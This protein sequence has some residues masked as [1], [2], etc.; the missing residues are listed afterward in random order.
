[1]ADSDDL[2]ATGGAIEVAR[3]AIAKQA[4]LV[5]RTVGNYEILNVI[6]E[7]GMGLVCRARRS[8]GTFEREV[9]LKL[10]IAARV[11]DEWKTRFRS[12]QA[13]LA[14][15]DHLH[16]TRLYDAGFSD[17][18]WPYFVMELIDGQHIDAWAS[19]RSASEIVDKMI[20]VCDAVAFAHARLVVHRDIKPSNVL[21]DAAGTVKLADFGIAKILDAPDDDSATVRAMTPRFASPEQLRAD[22]LTVASDVFQLGAL[23][24]HTLGEPLEEVNL[25][26]AIAGAVRGDDVVLKQSERQRLGRELASIIEK[27]LRSDPGHR[28]AGADALA[29]DLRAWRQGY[30]VSAVM[31]TAS[32]RLRKLVGRNRTLAGVLAAAAIVLIASTSFYVVN[33]GSA[34]NAAQAQAEAADRA[35]TAMSRLLNDTLTTLQDRSAEA[36]RGDLSLM[37]SVLEDSAR[38]LESELERGDVGSA[39]LYR[40]RGDVERRMGNVEAARE[41][42]ENALEQLDPDVDPENYLLTALRIIDV[43]IDERALQDMPQRFEALADLTALASR[44]LEGRAEFHRVR[45]SFLRATARLP[46]ANEASF[47]ALELLS[48][49]EGSANEQASLFYAITMGFI[50]MERF[51]DAKLN[52]QRAVDLLTAQGSPSNYRLID[53]LRGLGWA[54]SQ[55]NEWELALE[56]SENAVKIAKANYGEEHRIVTR[57]LFNLSNIA[58]RKGDYEKALEID[59]EVL[60]MEERLYGEL[61]QDTITTRSGIAVFL[62]QLGRSDEA[63]ALSLRV[64]EQLDTLGGGAGKS[65]R[66]KTL[67]F[68]TRLLGDLGNHDAAIAAARASFALRSEIVGAGSWGAFD[69]QRQLAYALIRGGRETEARRHFDESLAGLRALEN[70]DP[71]DIELWADRAYLFDMHGQDW[72]AARVKLVRYLDRVA[73]L[74]ELDAPHWLRAVGSLAY[75]CLRL[76]DFAC[77]RDAVGRVER[78]LSIAPQHPWA[79]MIRAV[80]LATRQAEGQVLPPQ[81][82]SGLLREVRTAAPRRADIA[83]VLDALP[84]AS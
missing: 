2:F 10:S 43:D 26:D 49:V 84:Q 41:A 38:V 50:Q 5:G 54:A 73:S 13:V 51:E 7:G 46:E 22:P 14:A 82:V 17:E 25:K 37:R 58:M 32:Y 24:R 55:L 52:A 48:Q 29:A 39:L 30:A 34:R 45:A 9:A 67:A 60:A 8:D 64:L 6:A 75:V 40:T 66:E 56:A 18:G 81:A 19:D 68:R 76:Q 15:L 69:G 77:T 72:D 53:P 83:A 80:D 23:L 27:A 28:Y 20:D 12:E 42:Y 79:L 21:V 70:A 47:E 65:V 35:S 63:D 33:L 78:T 62:A 3:S 44:D 71:N 1:M 74:H 4:Q 16:I 11:S 59:R 36:E 57:A 31:Q 61:A